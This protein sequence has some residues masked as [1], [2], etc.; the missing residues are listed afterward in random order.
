MFL[1][2]ARLLFQAVNV[3]ELAVLSRRRARGPCP[4][5]PVRRVRSYAA[6]L[7]RSRLPGTYP[8]GGGK[9]YPLDPYFWTGSKSWTD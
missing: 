4:L 8:V 5:F 7:T 2:G 3:R 1:E 9:G 6:L